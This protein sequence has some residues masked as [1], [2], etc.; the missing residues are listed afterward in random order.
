MRQ[1][2]RS[3]ITALC[4][5]WLR[6]AQRSGS[7]EAEIVQRAVMLLRRFP[8]WASGHDFLSSRALAAGNIRT[9]FA[10]AHAVAA[11]RPA[12]PS[13]WLLLSQCH[14]AGH[15]FEA[16]AKDANKALALDPLCFRAHEE[17]AAAL[18]PLE[19]FDEAHRHL[20]LIPK[21]QRTQ[22]VHSMISFL[23]FRKEGDKDN[24]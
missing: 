2:I 3:L 15:Q 20:E 18:I 9:A 7:V 8:Y 5:L 24:I 16:A 11:L 10:S 4:T 23:H 17:L 22:H 19:Q 12:S 14:L 21:E 6:A 1:L 13:S